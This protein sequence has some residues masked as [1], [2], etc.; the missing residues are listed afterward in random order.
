MEYARYHQV[1]KGNL[2][3]KQ[4]KHLRDTLAAAGFVSLNELVS[5]YIKTQL[6]W[7]KPLSGNRN[8]LALRSHIFLNPETD[9]LIAYREPS[10][11]A[12][13]ARQGKRDSVDFLVAAKSGSAEEVRPSLESVVSGLGESELESGSVVEKGISVSISESLQKL[14]PNGKKLSEE[15][16]LL[17][18]TKLADNEVRA[19]L[20]TLQRT[21]QDDL[22][23]REMIAKIERFASRLDRLEVLLG[24]S[25]LVEVSFGAECTNCR[26]LSLI[27]DG[28]DAAESLLRTAQPTCVECKKK[29]F[30][31]VELYRCKRSLVDALQQGL[32]LEALA[33]ERVR[34][35]TSRVW[36]GQMAGSDEVDAIA[37]F[38]DRVL[39]IECKDTSFGQNEFYVARAKAENIDAT[40]ICVVTTRDVHVNVETAIKQANEGRQAYLRQ[41]PRHYHLLSNQ[42]S[43][44]LRNGLD[45]WLNRMEESVIKGWFGSIHYPSYI[46][47]LEY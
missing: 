17:E 1:L 27:F 7:I 22:V 31:V 44:V 35:R 47:D 30:R 38:A 9:H 12:R 5:Q 4:N 37:V 6:D 10:E 45:D 21:F 36:A 26:E 41:R 33:L 28:R 39:L 11:S 46:F 18:C 25:D 15:P 3:N 20:Q 13:S 16:F 24:R 23:T 43:S 8:P 19:D 29:D 34:G 40:E 42:D 2:G 14:S 32:W